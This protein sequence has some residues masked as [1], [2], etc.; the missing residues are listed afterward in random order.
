MRTTSADIRKW[1]PSLYL[2]GIFGAL[3]LSFVAFMVF[4]RVCPCAVTPG[5]LLF[6]ELADEPISDWNETTANQENLCQIQIWAGIR[7][8]S[9]N[10]NCMATP[11]GELFLSCSVCDRKYWAA[12]VGNDE[13]AVLLN[14]R[15]TVNDLFLGKFVR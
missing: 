15:L 10:L 13:E 1:R 6:G 8:H 12:R 7:P 4:S 2:T 9:V 11:E 14:V 3:V 5:G